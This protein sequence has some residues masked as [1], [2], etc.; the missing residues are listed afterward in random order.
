MKIKENG[1]K[2]KN[3]YFVKYFAFFRKNL[4]ALNNHLK[5]LEPV[6]PHETFQMIYGLSLSEEEKEQ[7]TIESVKA[8]MDESETIAKSEP[9]GNRI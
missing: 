7:V 8:F 2:L 3:R 4:H 5:S 9:N 1:R 6:L